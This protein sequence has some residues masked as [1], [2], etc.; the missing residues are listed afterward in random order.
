MP[1]TIDR[2]KLPAYGK[3]S[4]QHC[5]S[6]ST[7]HNKWNATLQD[8]CTKDLL[9]FIKERNNVES[10]VR[11]MLSF[12]RIQCQWTGLMIVQSRYVSS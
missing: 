9:P 6:C 2:H 4:L 7:S 10:A 1:T 12:R 8:I 3:P 5:K 11:R